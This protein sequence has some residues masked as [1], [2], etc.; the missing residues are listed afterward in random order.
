MEVLLKRK[1]FSQKGLQDWRNL[2]KKG[3]ENYEVFTKLSGLKANI[4]PT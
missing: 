1:L 3:M 4:K 2:S